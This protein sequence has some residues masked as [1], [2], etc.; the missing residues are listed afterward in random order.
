M[1]RHNLAIFLAV[2]LGSVT[3]SLAV[4]DLYAYSLDSIY[5]LNVLSTTINL[6]LFFSDSIYSLNEAS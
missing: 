3:A 6:L 1:V 4:I 2:C 5:S